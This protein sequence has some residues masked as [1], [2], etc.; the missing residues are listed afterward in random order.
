MLN[1]IYMVSTRCA[2]I[3]DGTNGA[4]IVAEFQ[5]DVISDD[6]ATLVYADGGFTEPAYTATV[7]QYAR[8]D[9][10]RGES[11]AQPAVDE[12]DLPTFPTM[13]VYAAEQVDALLAALEA[14]VAALETP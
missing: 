12:Q 5:G 3:Y 4:E 11:A 10:Y 7:G 14:R 2:A 6:G 8:W 13:V 9:A 1:K